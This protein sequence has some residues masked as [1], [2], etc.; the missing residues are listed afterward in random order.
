MIH[1]IATIEIREG[2]REAFLA[3]FRKIIPL[4]RAE[5]GCLAYGPTVDLPATGLPLQ[6]PPRDNVVTI[7][8]QWESLE[9]LQAHLQAPHMLAYRPRVKD[10]VV[11]TRLHLLQP[12]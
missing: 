5:A 9:A 8:E 1:V 2:Q 12:V 11:S 4:V 7:V 6:V 10:L 3:E